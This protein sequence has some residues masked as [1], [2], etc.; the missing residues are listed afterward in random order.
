LAAEPGV[1]EGDDAMSAKRRCHARGLAA[2]F[3]TAVVVGWIGDA[4]PTAA[5]EPV[6]SLLEARR[7]AVVMQEWDLSCGA[8][9]LTTVL[10]YQYGDGVSER[11]V[12]TT[13]M[14]REEYVA[15]P[16]VVNVRQGFSLLDLKRLVDERGYEGVGLGQMTLDALMARVPAIV[17]ISTNGYNHFVVVRGMAGNRVLMAD[18]AWGNRTMTADDFERAWIDY[19]D[20]GRVAFVVTRE[21]EIA[22]PGELAPAVRLF[23]TFN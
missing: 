8:A 5:R 2:V 9:A 18:P 20:F 23:P 6:R 17:P 15:N 1:E 21:G 4:L 22:P 16:A 13:L 12:A 11:E 19:G 14:Q 3:V 10:N 7:D